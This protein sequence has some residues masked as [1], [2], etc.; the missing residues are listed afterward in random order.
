MVDRVDLMEPVLVVLVLGAK[1]IMQAL[2]TE[3]TVVLQLLVMVGWQPVVMV[4]WLEAV[5]QQTEEKEA[6]EV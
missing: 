1:E 5:V 6:S 2:L 3:A 4:A